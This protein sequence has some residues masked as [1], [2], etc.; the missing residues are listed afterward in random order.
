MIADC[1]DGSPIGACCIG[2]YCVSAYSQIRCADDGGEFNGEGSEC[3]DADCGDVGAC[4]MAG[5]YC[6]ANVWV[7]ACISGGGTFLGDGTSCG[8][9]PCGFDV[10]D[11][12][13]GQDEEPDYPDV[14]P[15]GTIDK[16]VI[17]THGIMTGVPGL[18]L[19]GGWNTTGWGG[20]LADAIGEPLGSDWAVLPVY[21]GYCV[22]P[23]APVFEWCGRYSGT[24]LANAEVTHVHLIA[25]SAGA[26]FVDAC[27]ERIR[28][29]RGNA[30]TIHATYLDPCWK[31]GSDGS[32]GEDADFAENYFSFEGWNVNCGAE[33][34]D[35]WFTES[36]YDNCVNIDVS[37][38][39]PNYDYDGWF[40]CKSS[41]AWPHCFYRL[42][43]DANVE[44]DDACTSS[45]GSNTYMGVD[46]GFDT[47]LEQYSSGNTNAWLA[48]LSAA[49]LTRGASIELPYGRSRP[50]GSGPGGGPPG[51]GGRPLPFVVARLDEPLKLNDLTFA[52]QGSVTVGNWATTLESSSPSTPAWVNF[53]VTPEEPVNM[54]RLKL[55][56]G[57]ENGAIGMTTVLIDGVEVGVVDE[58]HVTSEGFVT[59]YGIDWIVPPGKE[60]ILSLRLDTMQSGAA[61]LNGYNIQTGLSARLDACRMDVY[62]ENYGGRSGRDGWI[63]QSDLLWFLDD[64]WGICSDNCAPSACGGDF[65]LDCTVNVL[66]LLDLL[67]NWGECHD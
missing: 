61:S 34:V 57:A 45:H 36:Q 64:Q 12:P 54:V 65:N 26:G 14:D 52:K 19:P 55:T 8:G 35:T 4:C 53:A 63:R 2:G 5:A 49:G 37:Y 13:D 7:D 46:L 25:H 62:T 50:P 1:G 33:V 31:L 42:T 17:I 43:S 58:R 67:Q 32:R 10:P 56:P 24:V 21:T 20:R 38:L 39:D 60:F 44:D 18:S 6:Q 23:W 9:N 51:P 66:D 59:T 3:G 41:H 22:W 29:L 40:P 15:P 47:S 11:E 48:S 27:A 30:T 16:V 28:E